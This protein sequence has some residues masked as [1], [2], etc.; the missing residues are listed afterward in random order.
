VLPLVIV[1][2]PKTGY[3]RLQATRRPAAPAS[4]HVKD[5]R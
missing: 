5:Q 2:Q 3:Q 4:H 1:A